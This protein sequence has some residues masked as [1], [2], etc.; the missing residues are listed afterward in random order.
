MKKQIIA[1][2]SA[3]LVL[4]TFFAACG[5]G[6]TPHKDDDTPK[7]APQ[8]V[9][10]A[11]P[12]FIYDD[13]S[14]ALA[15]N[16]INQAMSADVKAS[17]L[18][19]IAE[20]PWMWT[21]DAG[22]GWVK[23][24][25]YGFGRWKNGAG[26]E[27]KGV[28]AYRFSAAGSTSLG[29]YDVKMNEL[30]SYQDQSIP[31]SGILL[32]AVAGSEES[33]RYTVK[34]DGTLTIPAGTFTALEQV[35]GVKTGF[36]AEDGVARSA[37]VRI[38]VNSAQ[39]Y[40][41]T[42][43][44]ATA[45]EDG[46]A[47]TQLSYPQIDDIPVKAGD[48][49]IIAIKL[50]AQANSD[51]DVSAP[52]VN[53]EDNWQVVRKSTQVLDTDDDGEKSDSDVMTDDGSIKT[54]T[55]FEFTFTLVRDKKYLSPVLEFAKT[56]MTRTGAEVT[57]AT[58][59]AEAKYEIV[60]GVADSRPESKKIYQELISAR[61][62]NAGDYMIRLVGTKLYI[63][64]ANDDAL[65]AAMDYF[66]D[67]FVKDDKGSVPAKYNYYYKPAHKVYELAGQNIAA[68]TIRTERYP[69]VVVMKAA[70]AI[71]QAVLEDCGYKLS[72]KGLNIDGTDLGENEIRVGPMNGSVQI[73]DRIYDTRFT[74]G[75]WQQYM[76]IESD[77][78]LDVAA[79]DY[80][81]D[82]KGKN[83]QIQGGE[84]YAINVGTLKFIEDLRKTQK[85]AASYKKTGTYTS[86]YD[87][88]MAREYETVDYS[89]TDGFGLTYSEDFDYEGNTN[90][91]VEKNV[92]KKWSLSPSGPSTK[93]NDGDDT[94]YQARPNIY[95]RNWWIGGSDGNN[96]LFE[97]VMKRV[98]ARGDGSDTGFEAVRLVAENKWG[99]RYGLWETRL[100]MGTRNGNCSSVWAFTEPPYNRTT[101]Y[102]EIDVYES[103]GREAFVPCTHHSAN[104]KYLGN[105]HFE[106]PHYQEACWV[107]PNEGEHY[108]DTFR[109]VAVDWCYDYINFYLD[110]VCVSRMPMTNDEEFGYYRN[111]GVVI[112]LAQGVGNKNYH[113]QRPVGD[114]SPKI[115][116]TPYWWM[117]DNVDNFFEVQV[118][119]YT[120]V[121]QT[122]NDKIEYAQ[123]ENQMKF[124]SNFGR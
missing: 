96:Y 102:L 21:H 35:A 53:E 62:D 81:I 32:S 84:S 88:D 14:Y 36:L 66:L 85:I 103:Y 77:G 82:F 119:D 59:G 22:E 95:G 17:N 68:Y 25:V 112:K 87:Y 49:V 67:T 80:V 48:A 120:R 39:V 45:A 92:L 58:E 40:S 46:V 13:A 63:I 20:S 9:I 72:I 27:A 3:F 107:E 124:V 56:I 5:D 109:H 113:S 108:Y 71:Q 19:A 111:A 90:A 23:R 99:F 15:Y 64:G 89:M 78:M 117:G 8:L 60:I 73:V 34:Q 79:G 94:Q 2:V 52:T 55:D 26:A 104:G 42:L 116:R 118:V 12:V 54:I 110:G 16:E 83:L 76:A 11:N 69:S 50:D 106:S 91:A 98:A 114:K 101:T 93:D 105:Y 100:V 10:A 70:E 28:F 122:D 1:L 43:C 29:V 61:L 38:I 33:L 37:S 57:T 44:N 115:A 7:S 31:N 121:Y 30:V 97:T 123:A 75:D 18:S 41:D 65:Q 47:V 86:Y 6:K 24:A 51:E 74:V 4:M